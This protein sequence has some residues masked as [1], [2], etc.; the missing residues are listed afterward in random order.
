M[1]RKQV[2]PYILRHFWLWPLVFCVRPLAAF[3]RLHGA[4]SIE[5]YGEFITAFLGVALWGGLPGIIIRAVTGSN[6]LAWGVILTFVAGIGSMA[7]FYY[8]TDL[9]VRKGTL[10]GSGNNQSRF[11]FYFWGLYLIPTITAWFFKPEIP[12]PNSN[13]EFLWIYL[14]LTPVLFTGLPFYPLVA[15][16]TLWQCR[17]SRARTD[18]QAMRERLIPLRWQSFTYPLPG[19]RTYLIG[20]TRYQGADTGLQTLQRLQFHSLQIRPTRLAAREIANHP[21]TSFPFCAM[22]ALHTNSRTLLPFVRTGPAA[23]AL[24][25][26]TKQAEK[27]DEQ[28]LQVYLVPFSPGLWFPWGPGRMRNRALSDLISELQEVRQKV[29]SERSRYA[30]D[31]LKQCSGF[32]QVTEAQELVSTLRELASAE[33]VGVLMTLPSLS[34]SALVA[35]EPGNRQG[36]SADSPCWKSDWLSTGWE[37]VKRILLPL[38]DISEYRELTTHDA[39]RDFLAIKVK[40]L[41]EVSTKG[42]P[43]FWRAIGEEI[44][45]HWIAT[46]ENETKQTREW[47]KLVVRLPDQHPTTGSASLLLVLANESTVVARDIRLRLDSIPGL[48]W[49]ASTLHHRL[50]EGRQSVSLSVNINCDE[51]SS[52]PLTGSIEARDLE[53]TPFRKQFSFRLPVGETGAPYVSPDTQPYQVGEGLGNDLT[54]VGRSE[55][56]GDL[57]GLW[58]QSH[59]KPAVVL[60]GQRRIGKTSL[61]NKI[62]R[63]GLAEMRLHPLVINIQGSTSAYDFLTEVANGMANAIAEPRPA[64]ERGEPYADF[65]QFLSDIVSKLN[66][67]RFLL[68]LDEADLIPQQHLGILM[69]GFLRTLMQDPRYPILLLFCGTHALKRIGREYDSILFNTAHMWRTVGYMSEAESREVLERPTRGIIEFAPATLTRAYHLTRGQPMLLQLIGA[70]LIRQFNSA[71]FAD[72]SRG[73]YVSPD[74]L[75]R[76]VEEII[77]QEGN[78]AFENHWN[79]NDTKTRRVL[80]GLAWALD[81]TNRPQLDISGIEAALEEAKLSLP[82]RDLFEVLERLREEE[83]LINHGATWRFAVPLYRRWIAWRWDPVSASSFFA[84]ALEQSATD[85]KGDPLESGA[86]LYRDGYEIVSVLGQGKFGITYLARDTKQGYD[87]AIK[88]YFPWHLV[89]RGNDGGVYPGRERDADRFQRGVRCFYDGARVLAKFTTQSDIGNTVRV[90]NHFEENGTAYMV[91][92]YHEGAR[93]STLVNRDAPVEESK[94]ILLLNRLLDSLQALHAGGIFHKDITP[95]NIFIR[96]EDGM[97]V[98]FDFGLAR[99]ADANALYSPPELLAKGGLIGPWTDIFSVGAVLYRL[100]SGK[101]PSESAEQRRCAMNEGREDPLRSLSA[102][103][104]TNGWH[105]AT[106]FLAAVDKALCPDAGDRPQDIALWREMMEL[107]PPKEKKRFP[108]FGNFWGEKAES[109]TDSSLTDGTRPSDIISETDAP[110]AYESQGTNPSDGSRDAVTDKRPVS[111]LPGSATFVSTADG[112]T[113]GDMPNTISKSLEI[114]PSETPAGHGGEDFDSLSGHRKE[115]AGSIRRKVAHRP[116]DQWNTDKAQLTGIFGSHAIRKRHLTDVHRSSSPISQ[117]PDPSQK[118]EKNQSFGT[119]AYNVSGYQL[120]TEGWPSMAAGEE[121]MVRGFTSHFDDYDQQDD[122]MPFGN[123]PPRSRLSPEHH[124]T[125]GDWQPTPNADKAD[126]LAAPWPPGNIPDVRK[127]F[128]ENAVTGSFRKDKPNRPRKDSVSIFESDYGEPDTLELRTNTKDH[129]F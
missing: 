24:V 120:S 79:D 25:A 122:A 48:H 96:K 117:I 62:Q 86:T 59:G 51:A 1:T 31:T 27:E 8:R 56:L 71:V 49:A 76:A 38:T 103:A 30:L 26:L 6:L 14:L 85:G 64:L 127:D 88:E 65:K 36:D 58:L 33:N 105:Y 19:I 10:Y 52:Y 125:S 100:I 90:Y 83:I 17:M 112:D 128:D 89:Y 28:P 37:T 21:D 92:E 106:S 82:D 80:S 61:L 109:D 12:G 9:R 84:Y 7:W 23:C 46:I 116:D 68:M 93:L 94:L 47:L 20:L 16:G 75:E 67:W 91:M 119:S 111:R 74:D 87:I 13:M 81:E 55:L 66:G 3:Q 98:L 41:R 108:W 4:K 129:I 104:D 34:R 5:V 39:R 123:L 121:Q 42:M 102:V 2:F 99:E 110:L 77:A 40:Q 114:L 115:D 18:N 11:L 44:I 35:E 22:L 63:D 32:E 118:E 43:A 101:P 29:L 72:E 53:G 45:D 107:T 50:L 73:N 54:F 95:Q 113:S 97:P 69:P 57:R 78:A 60:V 15:L 70:T 126:E 124:E